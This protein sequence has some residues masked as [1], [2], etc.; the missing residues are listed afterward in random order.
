MQKPAPKTVVMLAFEGAQILDI[1]GPMQMLAGVNDER[2]QGEPAYRLIMLAEKKGPLR[3]SGGITL[4][5]DGAYAALPKALDTL[6]IAGGGPISERQDPRL[7]DA[8]RKGARRARRVA[9]ICTGAFVLARAGLLS[10]RR[11]ATHWRLVDR[12]SETFPDVT[13]E[14]DALYVRDGKFWSSAGVTAGMDLALALIREDFGHDAALAVARRHVLFLMRPGGQSQFSAH[15]APNAFPEGRLAP[16]LR[17]IPEHVGEELDIATLAARAAMSERSFARA[18]AAETGVT[19]AR[20]VERARIDAARRLL[21]A[22]DLAIAR[23]AE[24]SGFGSDERMRR[25]FQRR[26][27]I[28]PGAFRARFHMEGA[29]Q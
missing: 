29:E 7:V 15:L 3:T 1:V 11:A 12:L 19:P 17:W 25:A 10:H 8:V 16:L 9:S 6:M 4:V 26:L 27:N 20:Y 22:S 24:R 2:P 28:S 14:R 23:V 5:A 21:S 18:F 13:V